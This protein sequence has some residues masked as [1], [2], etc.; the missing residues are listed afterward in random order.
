MVCA[1]DAAVNSDYF[2][3]LQHLL[4]SLRLIIALFFS[5]LCYLCAFYELNSQLFASC[6]NLLSRYSDPSG[7]KA[8][9]FLSQN[10]LRVSAGI[11]LCKSHNSPGK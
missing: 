7:K 1:A 10:R 6:L 9:K 2:P 3:L 5:W 11:V 4:F 8:I